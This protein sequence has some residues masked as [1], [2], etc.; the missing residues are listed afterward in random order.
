MQGP[1]V[2]CPKW[3]VL[4]SHILFLAL[5]LTVIALA[6]HRTRRS[7]QPGRQDQTPA[8]SS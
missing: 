4:P 7:L 6:V 2:P 1:V 5:A 8:L 3:A